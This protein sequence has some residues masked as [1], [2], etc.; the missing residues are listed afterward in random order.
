MTYQQW[1]EA[2][3]HSSTDYLKSNNYPDASNISKVLKDWLCETCITS[4]ST[5]RKPQL[6]TPDECCDKPFDLVHSDLS[7]KLLKTSFG[8]SNNYVTFIDDC[9]R[10]TWIYP[11]HAKSDTVKVFA[12]FIQERWVQN[13]V[14]IKRFRRDNRGEYVN[15]EMS[16]LLV[17]SGIIHDRTPAYSHESNGIEIGR[18]HV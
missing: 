2:F 18:A 4:K 1:H 11:I 17:R 10:Y 14:V 9:T 7:G 8:K 5:K 12:D 3:G 6:T 16:R 15:A 13:H